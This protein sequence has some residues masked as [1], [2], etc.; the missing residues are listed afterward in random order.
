MNLPSPPTWKQKK[1]P[2][3]ELRNILDDDLEVSIR[4]DML[5]ITSPEINVKWNA[6][7][8]EFRFGG[9]YGK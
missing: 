1:I 6:E 9:T 7:T 3:A 8:G 2:V 5:N 4:Y